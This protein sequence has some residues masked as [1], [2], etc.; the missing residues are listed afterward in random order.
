M[1]HNSWVI[2]VDYAPT[3]DPLK[4]TVTFLDGTIQEYN[5]TN[6]D[7][8]HSRISKQIL[9]THEGG[10]LIDPPEQNQCCGQGCCK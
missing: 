9:L 4:A 5:G 7:E 1:I 2:K 6:L 10:I 8:V 3:P